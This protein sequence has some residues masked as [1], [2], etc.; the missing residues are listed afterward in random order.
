MKKP[1]PN[2]KTFWQDDLVLETKIQRQKV[3][4]FLAKAKK[5][6]NKFSSRLRKFFIDLF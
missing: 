5:K 4:Y 6:N 3:E 2:S 1:L